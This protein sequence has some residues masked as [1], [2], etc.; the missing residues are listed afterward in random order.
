MG[1]EPLHDLRPGPHRLL[2]NPRTQAGAVCIHRRSGFVVAMPTCKA[3]LLGFG[4]GS[5]ASFA[6]RLRR[7][8]NSPAS[9]NSVPETVALFCARPSVRDEGMDVGPRLGSTALDCGQLEQ[10][11]DFGELNLLDRRCAVGASGAELVVDPGLVALQ[12]R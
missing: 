7:S 5:G 6:A 10:T 2:A 9:R 11:L 4:N 12:G 1:E 3:L 8:F